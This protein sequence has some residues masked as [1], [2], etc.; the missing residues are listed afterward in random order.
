MA[1]IAID[2]QNR[3]PPDPLHP[4]PMSSYAEALD[5]VRHDIVKMT[6]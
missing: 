1:H 3:A 6:E 2:V 4:V 5:S